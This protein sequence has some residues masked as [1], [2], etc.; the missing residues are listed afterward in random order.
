MKGRIELYAIV[1]RPYSVYLSVNP[2]E[3]SGNPRETAK[4]R[5]RERRSTRM[6]GSF[7]EREPDGKCLR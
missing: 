2:L 6:L 5:E 4:E 3:Q 7:R 1:R